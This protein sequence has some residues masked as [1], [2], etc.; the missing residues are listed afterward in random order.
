MQ[1]AACCNFLI[2]KQ[3]PSP[4][5]LSSRT[6]RYHSLE[7]CS[8][9]AKP[10]HFRSNPPAPPDLPSLTPHLCTCSVPSY[11]WPRGAPTDQTWPGQSQSLPDCPVMLVRRFEM[12]LWKVG[13]W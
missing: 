4:L 3:P 11:V 7:S 10:F 6:G 1:V 12:G 2:S 5:L 8:S 9:L 13:N